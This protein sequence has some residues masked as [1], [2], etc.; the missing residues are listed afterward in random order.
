[1]TTLHRSHVEIAMNHS[2]WNLSD[3][4]LYDLCRRHPN[5]QDSAV[6]IAKVLLIGR[7]YAA[8]IERRRSKNETND[9]FYRSK[10]APEIIKSGLD[11]WIG[12]AKSVT[13]GSV[14]AIGVM[15]RVHGLTTALFNQI[16]GLEKR[17]LA[18]KYLHFHVPGLFYIYDSRAAQGLR[19]LGTIVGRASKSTGVGDNE[20]RKFAEKCHLLGRHCKDKFGRRLSPRQLDNLLL[21]VQ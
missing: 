21:S 12:E 8:A 9:E 7:V 18:S 16:S 17:A 3:K 4:F 19:K 1:M 6:V 5:H 20:Y 13:P 14:E 15:V 2:Q 11:R 10:V